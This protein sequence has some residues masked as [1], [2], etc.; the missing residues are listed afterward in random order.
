MNPQEFRSGSRP[1]ILSRCIEADEPAAP[2]PMQRQEETVPRKL[3]I[4][5]RRRISFPS[6]RESCNLS[7]PVMIGSLRRL[8]KLGCPN[9]K[10]RRR[11]VHLLATQATLRQ[12]AS[13]SQ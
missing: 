6:V 10:S 12:I 11:T 5:S 4:S 3:L 2:T 8:L 9:A 1:S 7:P 13:Q